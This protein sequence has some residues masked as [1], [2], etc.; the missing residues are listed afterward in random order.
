MTI[1]LKM[2]GL[3]YSVIYDLNKKKWGFQMYNG[4]WILRLPI[5]RLIQKIMS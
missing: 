1:G 5:L 4:P 3:L 2:K